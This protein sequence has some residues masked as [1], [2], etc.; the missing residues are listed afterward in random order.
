MVHSALL[1]SEAW[2]LE[3]EIKSQLES[4]FPKNSFESPE[5]NSAINKY[6]IL[7]SLVM[8]TNNQEVPDAWM[9]MGKQMMPSSKKV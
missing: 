5:A 8:H 2:A 3:L 9:P 4:S 1:E 7:K 6:S